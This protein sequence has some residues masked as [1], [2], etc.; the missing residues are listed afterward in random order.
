[1]DVAM[2]PRLSVAEDLVVDA[3]QSAVPARDLDRLADE[4]EIAMC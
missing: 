2:Q 1:M 4:R 3:A